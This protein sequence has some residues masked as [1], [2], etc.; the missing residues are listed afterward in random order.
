MEEQHEEKWG[1]GQTL[2]AEPHPLKGRKRF[3]SERPLAPPSHTLSEELSE[4][5]LRAGVSGHN[6]GHVGCLEEPVQV[7]QPQAA[8]SSEGP[9][10]LKAAHTQD[11]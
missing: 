5:L 10:V 7:G 8:H 1:T 4:R 9:T 6:A 3:N 11:Q 2:E